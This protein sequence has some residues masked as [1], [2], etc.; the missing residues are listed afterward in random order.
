MEIESV[1]QNLV[2]LHLH[3][4]SASTPHFLWELAHEQGIRLP[5]KDYWK[6]I[7]SVTIAKKTTY[8]AYLKFFDLTE[9]IQSSTYAIEKSVHNAISCAYRNADVRT[10]EI[11]FNPMLRNKG[12]EQDLD[13]IIF[14]AVF[15]MR[16]AML[17]Y[18]VRAGLILM[19]DRRF[20]KEKNEIIAKKA[21]RFKKDGVVGLDIAG[22]LNKNFSIDDIQ[23]AVLIAKTGGLRITIHTGE[24]TPPQEIWEVVKKL[25]PHRIGHGIRSVEDPS[26]LEHLASK[27]IV[28]ELCPTSN[29]QTKAVRNWNDIKTIIKAFQKYR[30]LFTINSDGPEFLKTDVKNELRKLF[31]KKILT[32]EEI[33]S[34]IKVSRTSSFISYE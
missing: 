30:V 12:G 33:Q 14:S 16:N 17:E 29:I 23:H 9:L 15:G 24:V 31:H 6:F 22:P 5:E 20:E 32:I 8:D 21:V 10:I 19:M 13:K 28:L 2:D 3:L 34:I 26:L 27:K 4:G 18:P 1:L 11:R 7:K 25:K